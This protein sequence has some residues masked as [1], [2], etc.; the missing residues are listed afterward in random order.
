MGSEY[1]GDESIK[2][3]KE[4]KTA[5]VRIGIPERMRGYAPENGATVRTSLFSPPPLVSP[6]P[7]HSVSFSLSPFLSLPHYLN[8]M[9]GGYMNICFMSI[10]HAVQP[11]IYV[12]YFII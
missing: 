7:L 4:V 2:W 10:H 12:P 11:S 5:T 8:N 1:V 3:N 9:D 6:I